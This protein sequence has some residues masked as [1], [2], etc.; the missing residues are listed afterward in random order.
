MNKL[1]SNIWDI[2]YNRGSENILI[3][4]INNNNNNGLNIGG[5]QKSS[6]LEC[7]VNMVAVACRNRTKRKGLVLSVAYSYHVL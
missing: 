6:W 1:I 5:L 2:L 7:S 4:I 3:V